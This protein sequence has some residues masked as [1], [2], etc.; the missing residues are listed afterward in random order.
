[1]E[2]NFNT[3][4][5]ESFIKQ[6]KNFTETTVVKNAIEGSLITQ[7]KNSVLEGLR[8]RITNKDEE[9]LR[10][11]FPD[12]SIKADD[13]FFDTFF[14]TPPK[15]EEKIEEYCN[16]VFKNK[17]GL[18]INVYEKHSDFISH[19]IRKIITP[20]FDKIG[21]PATGFDVT[22]FI[23]NYGWTPLGI[24]QDNIGEN[25]MHFHLGPGKK[26]M[27]TWEQEKY[28]KLT[29]S[30]HNNFDIEPL[31]EYAN[32]YDFSEGDIYFMPW[33]KFHIGK[34]DELSIAVTLW[35]DNPTKVKFFDKV[36]NT[37]YTSYIEDN[38]DIMN[39][40]IDYENSSLPFETFLSTI[41][42]REYFLSLSTEDF[43]KYLYEEYKL[44][45]ASNGFWQAPPLSLKEKENYDV[46]NFMFLEGKV[47]QSNYPFKI[48][49]KREFNNS[50]S[51][52][53]RGSKINIKFNKNV[54]L[55]IDRINKNKPINVNELISDIVKEWS[56]EVALYII[57]LIY[58]KRGIEIIECE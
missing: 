9:G 38:K 28:N 14:N 10:I 19:K 57:S 34:A 50:L 40:V 1:M 44:S 53:V 48:Y 27:Y 11:Y 8:S 39:P 41:K 3:K 21:I 35:F 16:R 58:D 17:F 56:K 54:I 33:D 13:D 15:K 25:V 36:M 55:M 42:N 47:I 45:L 46:E 5:W 31:L 26:T 2:S 43:F 29:N 6:T 7:L 32:K 49:Y 20:L 23:G 30:K 18:I 37:F 4:W 22:V 24:H 52:F 51:I 12:E